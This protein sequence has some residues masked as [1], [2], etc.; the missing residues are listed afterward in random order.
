MSG[1]LYRYAA[2]ATTPDGGNPAGI[3]IGDQLP[4]DT[5]MQRIATEVAYPG[6]IFVAPADGLTRQVRYFS[7]AKEIDFCGHATVATGV[8]FGQQRGAGDYRFATNVGDVSVSVRERAGRWEAAL[9]SV[10]PRHEKPSA[11]LLRSA[12]AALHWREDELD[13][14]IPP[15]RIFAGNWHLLIAVRAADRLADLEYDFD[16]LRDLMLAD[17][18]VTLQLIWRERPDLFHARDPFPVG[19]VVEDPATGSGAA[20]LGG[21]LRDAGLLEAPAR[22]VIRQGETMGR[23][24]R[25]EVEIPATGGIVVS[26]T[27]TPMERDGRS[28]EASQP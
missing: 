10:V 17:G 23:P 14:A 8:L 5:E 7:P 28:C 26:G 22:I 1:E 12:L 18:L 25:I 24:S 3:W 9:T 19:G 16:R 27:A 21:Y 4:P 6:T 20:A 11:Q 2:F 13:P 15:A